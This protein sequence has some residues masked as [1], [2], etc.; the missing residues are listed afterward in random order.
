MSDVMFGFVAGVGVGAVGVLF[1]GLCAVSMVEALND[2][3]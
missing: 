1:L 2:A 3:R